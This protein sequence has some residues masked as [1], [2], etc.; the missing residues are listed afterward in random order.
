MALTSIKMAVSE[1]SPRYGITILMDLIKAYNLVQRYQFMAIVD[2]KI[3]VVT[4]GLVETLLQK[5]TVMTM[6]DE[7]R[8]A[9]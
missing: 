8:P 6:G 1:A 7:T 4:A 5:S 2:E 3:S 9:G